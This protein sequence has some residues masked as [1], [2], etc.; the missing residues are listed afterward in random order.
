MSFQLLL[1]TRKVIGVVGPEGSSFGDFLQDPFF[2]SFVAVQF[3]NKRVKPGKRESIFHDLKSCQLLSY[4]QHLFAFGKTSS[5]QV[6][7]GL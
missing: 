7:D 2:V 5:D 3:K 1:Q 4:K 6:R